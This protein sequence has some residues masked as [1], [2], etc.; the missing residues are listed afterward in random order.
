MATP[1]PAAAGSYAG[2]DEKIIARDRNGAEGHCCE[3]TKGTN[4]SKVSGARAHSAITTCANERPAGK[5][6]PWLG[7]ILSI[8]RAVLASAA[9]CSGR[10]SVDS[11]A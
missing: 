6:C 3:M 2:D 1:A 9:R 8:R 11:S 10:E 4:G 5:L 7:A